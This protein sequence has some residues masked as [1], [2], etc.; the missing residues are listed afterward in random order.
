MAY[1]DLRSAVRQSLDPL[2]Q[3]GISEASCESRGF[4]SSGA[5]AV[6]RIAARRRRDW[7]ERR[8]PSRGLEGVISPLP[9]CIAREP[10]PWT[11]RLCHRLRACMFE[12]SLQ[13]AWTLDA[14]H[15]R[16][17]D[18]CWSIETD[19]VMCIHMYTC[20]DSVFV[21]SRARSPEACSSW[22][23]ELYTSCMYIY[24]IVSYYTTLHYIMFIDIT[25]H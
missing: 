13:C 24:Y 7:P 22:I 18:H 12:D 14:G 16:V 9:C 3:I 11:S 10:M 20:G 21:S 1:I 4:L 17:Y 15:M 8:R 19:S 25:L 5:E 2:C 6:V 23:I